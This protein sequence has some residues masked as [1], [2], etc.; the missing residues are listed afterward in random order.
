MIQ[1]TTNST[2]QYKDSLDDVDTYGEY[3]N[4]FDAAKEGEYGAPALYARADCIFPKNAP[5]YEGITIPN[6]RRVYW[7]KKDAETVGSSIYDHQSEEL[8]GKVKGGKGGK[9]G[10][11][12]TGKTA[13]K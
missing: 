13:L 11:G 10:K 3:L 9:A 2:S 4:A 5:P 1:P 6:H 7:S 12:R 8:K